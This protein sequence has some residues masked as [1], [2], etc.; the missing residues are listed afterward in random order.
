MRM[1]ILTLE[2]LAQ[3]M[4]SL[5]SEVEDL[6]Y[7][8]LDNSDPN[9]PDY[10]FIPL[11]FVESFTAPAAVL[12]V[13]NQIIKMPLDW[14]IL[15]GD[16]EIGD[17]EVVPLTSISERGFEAFVNNPL[18]SYRPSFENVDIVDIYSDVK[19]YSPKL[20][21]GHLLAVPLNNSATPPCVYFTRDVSR[22]Q[23]IV[24]V[25]DIW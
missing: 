2:N 23:Q 5:P 20:R 9:D 6:R 3:D 14:Q 25:Q 21:G 1:N 7:A 22:T 15:V 11:V 17:L 12:Q 24:K 16:S 13:G 10:F 18:A 19:W 4:M 8:V